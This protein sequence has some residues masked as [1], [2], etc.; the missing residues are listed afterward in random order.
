MA[1]LKVLI[2]GAGIAGNAL[3]FWLSELDH[4]VPRRA[5]PQPAGHGLPGRSTRPRDRG[6]EAHGSRAGFSLEV[7][8]RVGAADSRQL[9]Q[10]AGLLPGE[11]VWQGAAELYHRLR[12]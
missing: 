2:S 9:G 1:R 12:D 5:V 4:D 3:V 8:P 7:G 11:Q 6:H 10:T